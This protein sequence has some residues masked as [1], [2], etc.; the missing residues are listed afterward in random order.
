V[1]GHGF[2]GRRLIAHLTDDGDQCEVPSRRAGPSRLDWGHVIYAAGVTADFRTRPYDTVRSHVTD[3]MQ[4]L[5]GGDFKSFLYLS[6]TRV[7]RGAADTTEGQPLMVR[8]DD[9]DQLYNLSKLMGESI[10]LS[11]NNP[12]VRVARVSNVYSAEFSSPNFLDTLVDDAVSKKRVVL[13]TDLRSTKDYV[14]VDDVVRLLAA[15]ARSGRHRIYNVASGENVSNDALVERIRQ[16]S[17][18][19]VEVVPAAPL[20]TFPVISIQRIRQEFSVRPA[21][22]LGELPRLVAAYRRSLG[23]AA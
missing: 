14:H 8:S 1:G 7:Y 3:L 17:G 20:V 23:A 21:S 11:I 15:I 6:T 10:C 12:R 2:I 9:A 18:C 16:V 13:R 19:T 5:D 22:I 4:V